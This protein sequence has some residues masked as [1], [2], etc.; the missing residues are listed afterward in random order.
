MKAG[1]VAI[2]GRTNA[3]KS[4]LIN[5]IVGTKVAITSP[6]PKTTKFPIQAVYEDERGQMILTDTPGLSEEATKERVDVVVY[7][8]DQT[9]ERG[10]EENK[11]IGTLRKF[12]KIPKI[13]AFNK[14]DSKKKSHRAQYLF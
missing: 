12:P 7:L 9:R 5:A 6:K 13:V 1:Y 10:G 3:G 11:V 2:I 14:I 8:I 4:T